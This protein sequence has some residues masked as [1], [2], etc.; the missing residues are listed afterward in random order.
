MAHLLFTLFA[1]KTN[2]I[3]IYLSC[4]CN[5][6]TATSDEDHCYFHSKG[7]AFA[8]LK[9][10]D[11]S[12]GSALCL[13][14]SFC[15][16]VM[17]LVQSSVKFSPFSDGKMTFPECIRLLFFFFLQLIY[18]HLKTKAA[19]P[20]KKIKNKKIKYCK[21]EQTLRNLYLVFIQRSL[22]KCQ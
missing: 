20:V 12:D 8:I 18:H 1:L 10:G 21:V 11:L 16:L 19:E 6:F 5:T 2:T 3:E 13:L 17:W 22:L 15:S 7:K 4:S 14:R 9:R